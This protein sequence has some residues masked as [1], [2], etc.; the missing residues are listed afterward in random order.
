MT[1]LKTFN[2][3]EL[4]DFVS[5]GDF[6]NFD[7]LPISEHRAKSQIKNLKALDNQTLLVL[8]FYDGKLAGYVGCFP[9]NYLIDGEIFHYAWLSTLFVSEEYR[10]KRIAKALLNKMFE[11]YDGNI[12]ATE[13]TKEAEALYNML[14]VFEYVYPKAGKRYYFRSDAAYIIPEKKPETKAAKPLFQITDAVANSLITLKNSAIKKPGFRFEILDHIDTESL[15]FMSEFRSRRNADEINVFIKNPW[16]LE[17]KKKDDQYLFSSYAEVFKYVWVKIYDDNS[18]LAACS[19][20]QLRDGNLKIPYL[21]SEA[22]DLDGFIDF[23]SY[24]IVS[25]KVKTLTS[26]QKELNSRIEQSKIFPKIY[27]RNFERR[28]LFH[29]QLIQHL[30]EGFDPEYQDGDGDCMMT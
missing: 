22:S 23:L 15:E 8:A 25:N 28:Y 18:N 1:E 3:K 11:E 9:D 30:P 20:L 21:F 7:F 2:K 26:Y 16:V 24:Y 29:K 19:L 4:E 13:F 6:R 17:G 10:G 5:S 27:E 14:G 12:I